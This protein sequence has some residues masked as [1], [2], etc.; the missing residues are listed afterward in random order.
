MGL[1]DCCRSE[2]QKAT[3]R[4]EVLNRCT[5]ERGSGLAVVKRDTKMPLFCAI[6]GSEVQQGVGDA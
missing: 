2:K 4:D 6:Q 1:R 5:T 3:S